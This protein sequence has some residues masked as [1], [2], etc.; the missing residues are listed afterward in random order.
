MKNKHI[1]IFEGLDGTGKTTIAKE[2][3]KTLDIQYFKNPMH[4]LDT[5][6]E[7]YHKDINYFKLLTNFQAPLILSFLSQCSFVNYGIILDRFTPSEFAYGLSLRNSTSV[8]I[9]WAIDKKLAEL[10]AKIIYCTKWDILKIKNNFSYE[11]SIK[12]KTYYQIY[13]SKTQIPWLELDT[14]SENISYQISE[15]VHFLSTSG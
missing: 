12:L 13:K 10:G 2:L 1:I 4:D 7:K 15:I 5:T 11:N 14:T 3:S 8:D 6:P 9:I